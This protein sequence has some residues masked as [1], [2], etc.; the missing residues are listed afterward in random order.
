MAWTM[1]AW[2]ANCR[3]FISW[4]SDGE[5]KKRGWFAADGVLLV[6]APKTT[7]P[8]PQSGE[9]SDWRSKPEQARRLAV[10]C[11]ISIHFALLKRDVAS[12]YSA[13]AMLLRNAS[14]CPLNFELYPW[15]FPPPYF[16]P[17]SNNE[18]SS[19]ST[20]IKPPLMCKVMVLPASLP[21]LTAPLS[22]SK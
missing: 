1:T 4:R 20:S 21:S 6:G 14:A 11:L 12:F 7:P 13:L 17:V 19:L 22:W 16:T 3:I 15:R 2:A 9:H 5:L 10:V 18:I 8:V